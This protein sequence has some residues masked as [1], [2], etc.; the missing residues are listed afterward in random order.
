M[1]AEGWGL[2][3]GGVRGTGSRVWPAS[4]ELAHFIAA[5]KHVVRGKRVVE[6]GAGISGLPA[7]V[8]ARAGAVSVLVSEGEPVIPVMY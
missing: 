6:L 7:L 3:P 1:I 4:L 8:S 2:Q 5:N